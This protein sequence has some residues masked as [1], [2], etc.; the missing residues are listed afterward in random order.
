MLEE[1]RRSQ[2]SPSF[3]PVL[4]QELHLNW[5][6]PFKQTSQENSYEM[7]YC[8]HISDIFPP[9]M[10]HKMDPYP[11]LLFKSNAYTSY[12][13]MLFLL[14]RMIKIFFHTSNVLSL[15]VEVFSKECPWL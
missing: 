2:N 3:S 1:V 9:S 8:G 4:H 15:D 10:V 14:Q 12:E 13:S 5:S 7:F 11:V 6:T